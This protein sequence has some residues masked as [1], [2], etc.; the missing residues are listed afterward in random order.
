MNI[1]D[2]GEGLSVSKSRSERKGMSKSNR[3]DK[4]KLKCFTCHKTSDSMMDCPRKKSNDYFIYIVVASDENSYESVGA[5]LVSSLRNVE[6]WVTNPS[7]S[8]HMYPRKKYFET[9]KLEQGVVNILGDNK[10]CMIHGMHW[11]IQT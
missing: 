11:Y 9:L 5:L 7:C 8:Y 1:D 3:F 4:S 6:V 2:S 10:A